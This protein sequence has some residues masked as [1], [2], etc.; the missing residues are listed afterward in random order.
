MFRGALGRCLGERLV[1]VW[2]ALG[3]CLGGGIG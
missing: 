1:D 3:R 2:G